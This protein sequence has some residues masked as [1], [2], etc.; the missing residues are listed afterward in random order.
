MR[1]SV[2]FQSPHTANISIK[3]LGI[4]TK[5][6]HLLDFQEVAISHTKEI[7]KFSGALQEKLSGLTDNR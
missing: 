4:A 3:F 5:L 2:V 6:L 7:S 1:A